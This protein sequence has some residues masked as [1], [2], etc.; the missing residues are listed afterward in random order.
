MI[1]ESSKK[2][3]KGGLRPPR[4]PKVAEHKDKIINFP[5]NSFGRSPENWSSSSLRTGE[6]LKSPPKLLIRF[7]NKVHMMY[8]IIF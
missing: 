6:S 4:P 8:K 2:R 5:A 1:K 3:M 7:T